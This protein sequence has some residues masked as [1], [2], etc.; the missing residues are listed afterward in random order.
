VC[1]CLP[2][3]F[4]LN[5][6]VE[7]ETPNVDNL[8]GFVS[9]AQHVSTSDCVNDM[10]SA[11]VT[12]TS[13]NISHQTTPSLILAYREPFSSYNS[14]SGL[15]N[16]TVFEPT[17]DDESF[18]DV[19]Q[20]IVLGSDEESEFR[21][22]CAIGFVLTMFAVFTVT[23]NVLVMAAVACEPCLQAGVTNYFVVSLAVADLVIGAVVMPFGIVIEV[24][25][26]WWPFGA[27]WCDVWHSFD[28]LASTASILNLSVIALDRYWAITDP[29]AY[30]GRMSTARA[31]VFIG[32]VWVCSATISFPAIAWWRH[33]AAVAAATASKPDDGGHSNNSS[34][35]LLYGGIEPILTTTKFYDLASGDLCHFTE[36][37]G[38][39][40]SSS[41]ISFYGPVSV[42]LF[43][44]Y[45]I[46]SAAAAQM[47]SLKRGSKVMTTT[48][49]ISLSNGAT[50][51]L[52]LRIHR[53]GGA[54]TSGTRQ[55]VRT[56]AS[57][58]GFGEPDS[59]QRMRDLSCRRS[60]G[61]SDVESS[62]MRHRDEQPDTP[63]TFSTPTSR[64]WNTLTVCRRRLGR[65]AR[66][67]KAAKTLGIVMGVFCACWVPFF[68]TNLLYGVC[69]HVG[70]VK[71]AD[72][73]FSVFT[74]L[75]YVNSGMNP[76]IYA[77]SMRDFR[78]AFGR[79]ICRRSCRRYP[80]SMAYSSRRLAVY[81]RSACSVSIT[82]QRHERRTLHDRHADSEYSSTSFIY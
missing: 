4:A 20:T 65:V 15:P 58:V 72:T 27:D 63:S 29:I 52:T 3:V 49:G 40:I 60:T 12:E 68:V 26:G 14:S 25:G 64:R 50:G 10:N 17:V 51:V 5:S 73:L 16:V 80:T 39:L 54:A 81:R 75:G 22:H 1:K 47:R 82:Q 28:V 74:W 77:C 24:T 59:S 2:A 55:N 48:D 23:G 38:Y 19:F 76:V 66:E 79:L 45:R 34:Q 78:R 6:T 46:Y 62:L 71:N 35:N 31:F 70:C 37:S 30:P 32:L 44:Y 61:A 56:R 57:S 43:A 36:D 9:N 18:T 42:I 69:R 21:W 8:T 41:L 67:R 33:S 13:Q 11:A 53:G 7:E